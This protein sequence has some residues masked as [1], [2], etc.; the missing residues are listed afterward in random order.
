MADPEKPRREPQE[1]TGPG[2]ARLYAL[3][4]GIGLALLGVLGFFYDAT[5]GTGDKLTSDDLA[6]ILN[7]NGWRNVV[8]VATGVLALAAAPRSP[9]LTALGLGAFYLVLGVWG[10]A[11]TDRGIG[12]LLDT[13][14]LGNADNAL[15]LILGAAGL[16]AALAGGAR[17]GGA[18][19]RR[20]PAGPRGGAAAGSR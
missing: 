1:A 16:L 18:G 5:F 20:A 6:G 2:P 3:A 9:R 15:H 8:Y 11:E 19:R 10:L 13:L 7:V 17:S 12:S 14:P 4:A